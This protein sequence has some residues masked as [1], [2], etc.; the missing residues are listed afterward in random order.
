MRRV[1]SFVF[2]TAVLGTLLG[3]GP[4]AVADEPPT[5]LGPGD[6]NVSN[7]K[8]EAL[9]RW[10]KWGFVYI[11][12]QQ[13]T[14]LTVTYD[15]YADTLLYAD[16]GTKKLGKIPKR[17][18]ERN[19]DKGIAVL[20]TIPDRF[21]ADDEKMYVQVWP[22][23]GDDRVDA[24]TLPSWFRLW[25]L[26][27][28]GK[29]VV[30]AG[31]GDDFVNGAMNPDRVY[32][33]AGDDWIRTGPGNDKLWGEGGTDKLVCAENKDTVYYDALEDP[34]RLKSCEIQILL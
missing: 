22:R 6:A 34:R 12:G 28:D 4:A 21:G 25:A 23:L 15:E 16:K 26:M 11:A 29:D 14:N 1:V 5:M 18:K 20:C 9:I 17:C 31:A 2:A 13:D 32:G 3:F 19:A 8:D 30:R 7:I 27:D 33:G 10:S 24:R